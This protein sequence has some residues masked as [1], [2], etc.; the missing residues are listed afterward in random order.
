[1]PPSLS[2]DFTM[3]YTLALIASFLC[4]CALF[5]PVANYDPP[6]AE[7]LMQ[8]YVE[9]D[10]FIDLLVDS[11]GTPGAGY[12]R[13]KPFYKVMDRKLRRLEFRVSSIP[14][15]ERSDS[16]VKTIEAVVIG[17]GVCDS[18]AKSLQG[19]HACDL[20]GDPLTRGVLASRRISVTRAFR[21]ALL[22]ENE[23]KRLK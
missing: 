16:L 8:L 22:Y 4:G 13:N 12:E 20:L 1:M 14:H 18:T 6:T 11:I 23:K 5:K 10:D 21:A 7:T 17:R 9:T 15:N 3:R 19:V 2:Y